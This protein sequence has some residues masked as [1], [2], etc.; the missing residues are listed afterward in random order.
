MSGKMRECE[1][2]V[3]KAINVLANMQLPANAS[4]I[5]DI[6]E[7]LID[8]NGE[9]IRPVVMLYNFSKMLGITPIIITARPDN[10]RTNIFTIDQLSDC[11]I[12]GYNSLY[13]RPENQ[14]N[15]Y[16]YKLTARKN[17]EDRGMRTVMSVGDMFWDIGMYGG[18]G[19]IIP[20]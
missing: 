5:F 15:V 9:C 11:G 2:I 17:V 18:V 4:I 13:L 7:T 10:I 1:I 8:L 16:E 6:D 20:K 3:A 14:G 19:I 12:T